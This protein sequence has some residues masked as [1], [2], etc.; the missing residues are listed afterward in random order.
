M[1]SL[2]ALKAEILAHESAEHTRDTAGRRRFN[3]RLG[4]LRAGGGECPRRATFKEFNPVTVPSHTPYQTIP[5]LREAH[6]FSQAVG[7][8]LWS[9]LGEKIGIMLAGNSGRPAGAIGGVRGIM[10]GSMFPRKPYETQ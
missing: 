2:R 6:E 3:T 1:Q 10:P 7:Y 9:D 4:R 8:D 5:C